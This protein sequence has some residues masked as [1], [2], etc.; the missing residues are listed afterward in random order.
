MSEL[1]VPLDEWRDSSRT[2]MLRGWTVRWSWE[3]ARRRAVVIN[4]VEGGI[5]NARTTI[6][7]IDFPSLAFGVWHYPS[8]A[9]ACLTVFPATEAPTS[10]DHA[11]LRTFWNGETGWVCMGKMGQA[12]VRTSA[13]TPQQA[14]WNTGFRTTEQGLRNWLTPTGELFS[15]RAAVQQMLDFER[16][17]RVLLHE[18]FST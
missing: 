2:G 6:E 15:P 4:L 5:I 11:V 16:E 18:K 7:R 10:V 8:G 3:A 9:P 17:S 1:V 13:M 12:L 14:Y